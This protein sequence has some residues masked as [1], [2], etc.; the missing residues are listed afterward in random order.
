ML[1]QV[2]EDEEDKALTSTMAIDATVS[3]V[4]TYISDFHFGGFNKAN[5]CHCRFRL[6]HAKD[7]HQILHSVSEATTAVHL[8][9]GNLKRSPI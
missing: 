4:Q 8:P 9:L 5:T 2:K 7:I 3:T 1:L 6:N